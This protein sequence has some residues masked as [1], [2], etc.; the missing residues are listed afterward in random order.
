MSKTGII[1]AILKGFC[2]N[3]H[4]LICEICKYSNWHIYYDCIVFITFIHGEAE[5][6]MGEAI[7]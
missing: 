3:E 7:R 6:G 2:G 4:N 5:E 1:M